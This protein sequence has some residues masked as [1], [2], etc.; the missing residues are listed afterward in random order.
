M[1]ESTARL[2]V[3]ARRNREQIIDAARDIFLE[4][5]IHAPLETIARRA[6]VGIATLYRRF[7]D[8]R[9]LIEQ[10]A[11]DTLTLVDE[12][13]DAATAAHSDAWGALT[14]LLRRLVKRRITIV[15]PMLLPGLEEDIRSGGG[16]LK[17]Q[18]DQLF[19]RMDELTRTAQQK[20]QLR[21]GINP[22][23]L[24]LGAVKLSRPL[25][26]I[27]AEL[28]QLIIDRQL[29][30]FLGSLHA[31]AL[32]VSEPLERPPLTPAVIDRYLNPAR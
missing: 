12:E 31:V 22:V 2:R 24:W 1:T 30:L 21:R 26:V 16:T 32:D 8:R 17:E 7:P 27:D 28:N 5:G 29:E 9:T 6:G 3:D 13:L 23:D 15:M 11:L 25:P 20:G 14:Q 18:S 4:Q 10:V 19:E